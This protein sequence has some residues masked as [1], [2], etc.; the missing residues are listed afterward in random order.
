MNMKKKSFIILVSTFFSMLIAL[1]IFVLIPSTKCD[2]TIQVDNNKGVTIYVSGEYVEKV[3]ENTYKVTQPCD[4]NIVAVNEYK[5]FTN[6]DITSSDT[7]FKA[8]DYDLTSQVLTLSNINDGY[9][10]NISVDSKATVSSDKGKSF[11]D[12]YTISSDIEL[13]RLSDVFRLTEAEFKTKYGNDEISSLGFD[14]FANLQKAYQVGYFKL[15]DNILVDKIDE[16]YGIG[17]DTLPFSGCFDF[18]NC[19][20]ILNISNT[21]SEFHD[22]VGLFGVVRPTANNSGQLNP[23]VILNANVKGSIFYEDNSTNSIDT[24]DVGALAGKT[25]GIVIY[26]NINVGA[27]INIISNKH[28]LNVGGVFGLVESNID[29]FANVSHTGVYSLITASTSGSGADVNLGGFA[30][31]LKDSYCLSFTDKSI[32]LTLNGESISTRSGNANVAGVFGKVINSKL[33]KLVIKNI[34]IMPSDYK[35]IVATIDNSGSSSSKI[36]SSSGYIASFT[37]SNMHKIEVQPISYQQNPTDKDLAELTISSRNLK[38]SSKGNVYAGGLFGYIDSSSQPYVDFTNFDENT[39]TIFDANVK[40]TAEQNGIGEVYAGGIYANYAFTSHPQEIILT[41]EKG[42]IEVN[43]IQTSVTNVTSGT[44][45]AIDGG[46]Y[47]SILPDKYNITNF[48]L[49]VNN[50]HLYCERE[51]GSTVLGPLYVGGFTGYLKGDNTNDY[52]VSN[53]NLNLNSSKIEGLISSFDGKGNVQV[54]DNN[55]CVGGFIGAIFDYGKFENQSAGNDKYTN[56]ATISTNFGFE[57]I[58]VNI[59]LNESDDKM[60]LHALQNA[61]SGNAD[62]KTEGYLGGVIGYVDN[63]PLHNI[64]INSFGAKAQIYFNSTNDPNTSACGGL[65]GANRLST[66]FGL[67]KGTV[68]N[69]HIIGRAY[70]EKNNS[71]DTY[72]LFVGGAIGI[73]GYDGSSQQFLTNITVSETDI[74]AIGENNMLTYAGGIAGGAFWS[75]AWS[76]IYNCMY[77]GGTVYATSASS[78]AFSAGLVGLAQRCDILQCFVYN[79][80]IVA[81]ANNTDGYAFTAGIVSRI[82]GSSN[83]VYY[84]VSNASLSSFGRYAVESA[85]AINYNSNSET[86]GVTLSYCYYD[87]FALDL[88]DNIALSNVPGSISYNVS[89]NKTTINSNTGT[90]VRPLY[91]AQ[92]S[93]SGTT[94]VSSFLNVK[95][96][97]SYTIYNNFING[98]IFTQ[99]GG[100]ILSLSLEYYNAGSNITSTTTNLVISSNA[101]S[102]IAYAAIK[103]THEPTGKSYIVSYYPIYIEGGINYD[104]KLKNSDTNELITSDNVASY[105]VSGNDTYIRVEVGDSS[106][107]QNVRVDFDPNVIANYELYMPTYSYTSYANDVD[108]INNLKTNCVSGTKAKL[109]T[110]N[111]L[112]DIEMGVNQFNIYPLSTLTTRTVVAF[113]FNGKYVF[114]DFVPDYIEELIVTPSSKTPYIAVEDGAY[115]YTPS[116]TINFDVYAKHKYSESLVYET[117]I[118]F[119]ADSSHNAVANGSFAISSNGTARI[120]DSSTAYTKI[121]ITCTYIGDLYED[122]RPTNTLYITIATSLNLET[123]LTGVSYEAKRK[124][125]YNHQYEFSVYPL[126]GYGYNPNL[127]KVILSNGSTNKEYV[128]QDLANSIDNIPYG[129]ESGS[130]TIDSHVFTY[131]YNENTQS[132]DF[133]LPKGIFTNYTN[134]DIVVTLPKIYNIIFDKGITFSSLGDNERYFI[135]TVKEG[136]VIDNS[137]FNEIKDEIYVSRYGYELKGYY[138]TDNASS[139]ENYGNEFAT[140]ANNATTVVN[141]PLY[142]YSR[143]TYD[144]C[145][146]HPYN[147]DVKSSLPLSLLEITTNGN[148]QLVPIN[149]ES[150]FSFKI[151]SD[152]TFIGTPQYQV[153][154]IDQDGNDK[155]ITQNCIY[156]LSIDAY[157]I[158]PEYIDGVIYIKVFSDSIALNNG[159]SELEESKDTDILEDAVFTLF[160]VKNYAEQGV[161]ASEAMM[162][163][164]LTFNFTTAL[165]QG[166]VLR[167]YRNINGNAVDVADYTITSSLGQSVIALEEFKDILTEEN[168][169]IPLSYVDS[170]IFY[171]SY[172]IVITL[173]LYVEDF[174]TTSYKD[175]TAFVESTYVE[176]IEEVIKV[177][178]GE[179]SEEYIN[180]SKRPEEYN[181]ASVDFTVYDGLNFTCNFINNKVTF[182]YEENV[183]NATDLR[184]DGKTFMWCISKNEGQDAEYENNASNQAILNTTFGANNFQMVTTN[185]VYYLAVSSTTIDLTN[186]LAL[187][188]KV[189]LIEVVNIK[190][191]ASNVVLWETN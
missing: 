28:N 39:Y 90:A 6:F 89:T 48:T 160:Y 152:G 130:I 190:A 189:E 180:G 104:Y 81:I 184:H 92:D 186:V 18:N 103:L 23:C 150:K 99:D 178:Y 179:K 32:G 96:G 117:N 108:R 11:F 10:F 136:T 167:L 163:K 164:D 138:L 106:K 173:P 101:T 107:T 4:I 79:A 165:P 144:I 118:R 105:T 113:E 188:Y 88:D 49:T 14:T 129:S 166:T 31:L 168:L 187:G 30:G 42:S 110:F 172:Y 71:G 84:C 7:S 51:V 62:N 146:E 156:N 149:A 116:D 60:V 53:I 158:D 16:F 131:K 102:S 74:N 86:S 52:K 142:F 155:E 93:S 98:K 112:I 54:F 87:V 13:I 33:E 77:L 25:S 121:P 161:N 44:L 151:I 63:S 120:K 148:I 57:D 24:I 94:K 9:N 15:T 182:N 114:I 8:S 140:I 72:D 128:L 20:V 19:N 78:K 68:N 139:I 109:S 34:T 191:P 119:T 38:N 91:L 97:N 50:G 1:L 176:T 115:V 137:I 37:A 100:S 95:S 70:T 177:S 154:I 45:Y 3:N 185:S 40:V 159:E 22:N 26:E 124:V 64:N 5:L 80:D 181:N 123:N 125:V 66:S 153:F 134:V 73:L 65:I 141:A 21:L 58:Y 143:W 55:L 43:S 41:S 174:I 132:Y 147:I 76:Q 27:S 133:V 69:I 35:E 29:T 126:T 82:R 12:P 135:Y 162:N 67:D 83:K 36:P 75:E 175:I 61:P 2:T 127:V 183:S 111:G 85:T 171:E 170:K 46:F 157:E 59:N 169:S 56:G 47:S 17:N 122:S 145:I